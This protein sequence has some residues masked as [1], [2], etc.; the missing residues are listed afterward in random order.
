MLPDA[1]LLD[2]LT[3]LDKI[4]FKVF[5]SVQGGSR[6]ARKKAGFRMVIFQYPHRYNLKIST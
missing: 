1:Q 3:I 4:S 5:T 6:R 2:L